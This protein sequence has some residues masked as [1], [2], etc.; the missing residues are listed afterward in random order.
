M[1]TDMEYRTTER[2]GGLPVYKKRVN[3]GT[4]PNNTHKATAVSTENVLIIKVA[5]YVV[6][7]STTITLPYES[8]GTRYWC[9][10]TGK[11][12]VMYTNASASSYTGFAEVWYIKS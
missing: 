9:Y 1:A 8:A 7:S 12:V 3:C 6:S 4:L 11:S 2:W 10:A 5:A